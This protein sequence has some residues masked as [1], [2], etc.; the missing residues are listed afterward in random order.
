MR[1]ETVVAGHHSPFLLE[2][3]QK[4]LIL[5]YACFLSCDN[6]PCHG[7]CGNSLFLR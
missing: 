3:V 7:F 2:P 5:R 6:F 1:M 4:R